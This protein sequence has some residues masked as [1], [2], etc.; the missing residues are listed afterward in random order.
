M[1]Y[2]Y[3]LLN[4]N[5]ILPSPESIRSL[6]EF[7]KESEL[8]GPEAHPAQSR[9]AQSRLA[10]SSSSVLQLSFVQSYVSLGNSLRNFIKMSP[11]AACPESIRSLKKFL[12]ESG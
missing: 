11:R 10:Q 7:L 9:P 8:I 2:V 1:E 12:K 6:E 5:E 3:I 4:P